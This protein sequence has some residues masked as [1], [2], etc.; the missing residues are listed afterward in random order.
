MSEADFKQAFEANISKYYYLDLFEDGFYAA[1]QNAH[2]SEENQEKFDNLKDHLRLLMMVNLI[3]GRCLI[4]PE[5]WATSSVAAI[6]VL[7][8]VA[9]G[10]LEAVGPGGKPRDNETLPPFYIHTYNRSETVKT[11]RGDID[12]SKT[13][14]ETPNRWFK[15]ALWERSMTQERFRI[16]PSLLSK[17]GAERRDFSEIMGEIANG[18][19]QPN[20]I[21]GRLKDLKRG[22]YAGANIPKNIANLILYTSNVYHPFPGDFSQYNKDVLTNAKRI[23]GHF[24]ELKAANAKVPEE[25]FKLFHELQKHDL[26]K[27]G[28]L[29][30]VFNEIKAAD[31]ALTDPIA[32]II[33][34]YRGEMHKTLAR[35][36]KVKNAKTTMSAYDSSRYDA[37][38]F[39]L[40]REGLETKSTNWDSGNDI[41]GL[42]APSTN[43]RIAPGKKIER[44]DL[45]KWEEF[46]FTLFKKLHGNHSYDLAREL[47]HHRFVLLNETDQRE[48]VGF[49]L[50]NIMLEGFD[51][52]VPKSNAL[53]IDYNR[54]E[55]FMG[56]GKKVVEPAGSA[57]EAASLGLP[58]EPVK[59]LFQIPVYAFKK[60]THTPLGVVRKFDR[61]SK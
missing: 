21:E 47:R 42:L 27:T 17:D 36:G 5:Q 19:L 22:T 38:T 30:D 31:S 33:R 57:A 16:H 34:L 3:H 50:L 32:T 13:V 41:L 43:F 25:Y 44:A 8:E 18:H 60:V 6:Q 59:L 2:L 4:V 51:Y 55:K 23:I 24:G 1:E 20:E 52:M 48:K 45:I 9:G 35:H 7:G 56:I 49:E 29:M 53:E 61:K 40:V 10:Y 37:E 12:L 15:A 11:S 54:F 46:W 58:I 26:T 39:A 28:R 14:R